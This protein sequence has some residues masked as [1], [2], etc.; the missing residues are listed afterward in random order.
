MPELET[1]HIVD[2]MRI[3]NGRRPRVRRIRPHRMYNWGQAHMLR[4]PK[5]QI[6]DMARHYMVQCQIQVLSGL[7]GLSGLEMS[8]CVFQFLSKSL[9]LMLSFKPP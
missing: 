1:Q 4:W 2:S 6:M 7:L 5:I 3:F 9:N 8:M